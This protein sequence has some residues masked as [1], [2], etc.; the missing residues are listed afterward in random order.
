MEPTNKSEISTSPAPDGGVAPQGAG[1]GCACG[2][3]GGSGADPGAPPAYVYAIG[4]IQ[5]RFSTLGVEKELAQ[6]VGRGDTTGQTDWQAL[7]SVLSKREN[8]YLARR[9]CW[10]MSIEGLDTYLLQP[11]IPATWSCSSMRSDS[12]RARR[13]WT[14]SS[15]CADRSRRRRCATA[16]R[17]PSWA[18]SRST[19][20]TAIRCSKP[21][22]ARRRAS[23]GGQVW[24]RRRGGVLSDQ[25][26]GGQCRAQWDEH[27]ALNY[28]AVRYQAIY[29]NAAE[30]F[31]RNASLTA[32]DRRP[33]AAQQHTQDCGCRFLLHQSQHGRDGEVL[34]AGGC[35]DQFPF[36]VTKLSPL[37]RSLRRRGAEQLDRCGDG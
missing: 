10:V 23:V 1:G 11:P 25:P 6:V 27:R 13:T 30:A 36:L 35:D 31:S 4:R 32:V 7:H 5:A 18:S 20:L 21:F 29:A 19:R 8:R 22:R 24:R 9:L 26:S 17:C 15:A 14:W 37:L 16:C 2:G 33:L 34:R 12:G 3:N 28:L